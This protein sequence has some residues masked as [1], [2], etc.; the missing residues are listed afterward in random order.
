MGWRFGR[1]LTAA[2]AFRVPVS[3][4]AAQKGFQ[5]IVAKI[6]LKSA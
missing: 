2:I 1:G 4:E 5:G 3:E 6:V